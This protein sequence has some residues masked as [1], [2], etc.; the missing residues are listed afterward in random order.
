MISTAEVEYGALSEIVTT[1]KLI[2][3]V[4]QLMEIDDELLITVYV[5]NIGAIVLLNNHTTSNPTIHVDIC[6]HLIHEY[7]EDGMVK[8]KFLKSEE[9]TL[10]YLQRIYQ[11]IYLKSM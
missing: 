1:L 7:V 8:F 4:L 9:T 10:I 3:M 5:D 6:Y 11:E 2:V